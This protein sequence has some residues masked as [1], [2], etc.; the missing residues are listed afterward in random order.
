MTE[1]NMDEPVNIDL[2]FDEALAALLDGENGD[3]EPDDDE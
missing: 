3:E 2:D 1:R